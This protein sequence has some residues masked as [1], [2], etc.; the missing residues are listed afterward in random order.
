MVMAPLTLLYLWALPYLPWLPDQV[1]LILVLAGPA[2]WIV[3]GLAVLGSV[4]AV[5]TGHRAEALSGLQLP[6]HRTVFV[7]TLA[8]MLAVGGYAKSHQG[9]GG[10][11]PHY[12]MVAHS[13]LADGDLQI[14]NNHE[15]RHYEPFWS[16]VL[17]PHFLQRGL[18]QVIYSVHAPGLP[19]LLLPFYAVAGHW[20]AMVFIVLL[21]SLVAVAVFRLAE[22]LTNRRVAWVT[23]V[24]VVLTIP[25]APQSWLIFPEMPAALVM[26]WVA[27]WLFGPLPARA[28]TWIWRGA[29]IAFLP[30]LHMKYSFLLVGATVCLLIRLWPRVVDAARLLAPMAV[31][32]LLWFGSFY[33]MYGTP[34]PTVA[35]GYGGGAG[36]EL[37]NIPRGILGLL[38]DQ[39]FGLLLYSP[40]YVLAVAGAWVMLKRPEMRWPMLGLVATAVGFVLTV[41][42]Y[43]MWWGGWSVPA[44]FLLP[45][46]PLAVPM[47]AVAFDE[48]RGTASRGVSGL[49]LLAS[50]GS[51]GVVMYQPQQRLLFNERDGTGALVEAIQGAMD[52]TALLPSFIQPDWVSQLPHVAG[53][54]LAG[55]IA[56]AVAYVASRQ[57]VTAGRA[58]WSGVLSLVGFI[59][60]GSLV[61]GKGLT[62]H[63]GGAVVPKGQ[64]SMIAAFDGERLLAYSYRDRRLLGATDLF[65]RATI[66]QPAASH[67]PDPD[68]GQPQILRG[69]VFGPYA[70]PAGR[71]RVRVTVD[72]TAHPIGRSGRSGRS[73]DDDADHDNDVW[74]AHHRGP[75]V[76][77]QV[78]VS[79]SGLGEMTLDL[80]VTLDPLWVG[81]SSEPL[82]RAITHVQIEPESVEPRTGRPSI[83]NIRQSEILAD[84][85]GRYTIH[86]DDNTYHEPAGF[87]V[88][89]GRSAS[90]HVSPNGASMLRV[91]VRNG[92]VPGPVA[93]EVN[94]IREVLELDRGE[95]HEYR[96][97]LT[98]QEVTVPLT[99][100]PINGFRP[101]ERNP[102]SA[103]TR[104]LG[105]R[106]ALELE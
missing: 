22:R 69:R 106:V 55:A 38:F 35:Y 56:G 36:L 62:P 88:R 65:A 6:G 59:A 100:E 81:A 34:N 11:E 49:L 77:S 45:V 42:P 102:E 46:L 61:S 17:P 86:V 54:L 71:Y 105:C 97:P 30:W 72:P 57:Q 70:L 23:W 98:G 31:S 92:A 7:V 83:A 33:V 80:P 78:T 41:V 43:Y 63:N 37:S 1:P 89:G 20:G 103:D 27:A 96:V 15:A 9:L 53:W 76:I 26:A 79:A 24:A 14:E 87:W 91:K 40:V 74:V 82:A 3:L 58:F 19:V 47:I 52:L 85:P 95:T 104:W 51:F 50:V 32:G 18:N 90:L 99:F 48:C 25:F 64:Q 5:V 73:N 8:L 28:G 39:E 29:V 68:P 4:L 67:R 101:S 13:L 60:A 12:L 21:S 66:S 94:G 84:T 2:R 10:D 75:G 16:A 44:R 93:V